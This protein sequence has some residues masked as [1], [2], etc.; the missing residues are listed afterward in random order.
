MAKSKKVTRKRPPKSAPQT[1]E[2][3]TAENT[4]GPAS[5]SENTH[6]PDNMLQVR[7]LLF[8]E[9]MRQIQQRFDTLE[10]QLNS[11]LN[12]LRG[13][14]DQRLNSETSHRDSDVAELDQHIKQLATEQENRLAASEDDLRE[15]MQT[16]GHELKQ[17]IQ[18]LDKQ[19]QQDHDS[20]HT[21][22]VDRDQIADL[23]QGLAATLRQPPSGD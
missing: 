2:S 4:G 20:L 18:Q 3:P 13:D 6:S 16:L 15:S 23:L 19:R 5:N 11:T 7:E 17:L 8:G 9:Q 12:Q 10:G 21:H 1:T 14:L 22:K